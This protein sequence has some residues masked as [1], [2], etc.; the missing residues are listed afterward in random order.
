MHY[1]DSIV[2]QSYIV[3][4]TTVDASR[5]CDIGSL[6][7]V[8]GSSGECTPAM[9]HPYAAVSMTS[10]R[11]S[12]NFMN[13]IRRVRTSKLNKFLHLMITASIHLLWHISRTEFFF[14]LILLLFIYFLL[15]SIRQTTQPKWNCEVIN[16]N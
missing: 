7:T 15:I 14:L 8:A 11:L 5:P 4:Q 12:W 9:S 3:K 16:L 10:Q 1:Q 2:L 6:L 13:E